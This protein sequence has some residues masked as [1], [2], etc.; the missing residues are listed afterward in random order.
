MLNCF[1]G[2]TLFLVP[3]AAGAVRILVLR[4][5]K[6]SH[7]S[8]VRVAVTILSV[9]KMSPYVLFFP[10][11]RRKAEGRLAFKSRTVL[12]WLLASSVLVLADR[13]RT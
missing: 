6:I 1:A 7:E 12:L 5:L 9:D 13:K 2:M 10:N 4:T 3:I 8:V 11:E